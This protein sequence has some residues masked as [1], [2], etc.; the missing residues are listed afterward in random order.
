MEQ[1]RNRCFECWAG[2]KGPEELRLL[3][4]A[5]SSLLKQGLMGDAFSCSGRSETEG[6]GPYRF[7]MRRVGGRRRIDRPEAECRNVQGNEFRP[8]RWQS[9][10]RWLTSTRMDPRSP[11][12]SN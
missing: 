2:N 8:C 7:T 5:L 4:L 6:L 1:K 9:K 3:S 10:R 12:A 11:S